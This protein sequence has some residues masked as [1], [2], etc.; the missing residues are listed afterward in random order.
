MLLGCAKT[1]SCKLHTFSRRTEVMPETHAAGFVDV[2][3]LLAHMGPSPPNS[4][5]S[6]IANTTCSLCSALASPDVS[7]SL[8]PLYRV[9]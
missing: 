8:G 1:G 9:V 6:A 2:A 4:V 5:M 3:P 7:L